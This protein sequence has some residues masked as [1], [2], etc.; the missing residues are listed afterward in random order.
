MGKNNRPGEKSEVRMQ[1]RRMK[2][3]NA[4]VEIEMAVTIFGVLS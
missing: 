3:E 4:V 2:N 1:K